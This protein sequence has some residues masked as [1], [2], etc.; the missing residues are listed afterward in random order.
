MEVTCTYTA[1]LAN[2]RR[3]KRFRKGYYHPFECQYPGL[4]EW[5]DHAT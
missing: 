1:K 3:E 5:Y 2:Q 4:G